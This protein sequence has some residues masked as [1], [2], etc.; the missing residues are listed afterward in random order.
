MYYFPLFLRGETEAQR[1]KVVFVR[2]TQL[3]GGKAGT[4]TRGGG[5][6]PTAGSL[7]LCN[8]ASPHTWC[9]SHQLVDIGQVT[10]S[11][12]LWVYY[13]KNVDNILQGFCEIK[14]R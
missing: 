13:L 12:R 14:L 3:K 10:E 6:P 9:A 5:S 8:T 2:P 4:G 7:L 1:S 11:P